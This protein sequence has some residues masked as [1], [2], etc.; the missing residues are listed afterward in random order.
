MQSNRLSN[1]GD[2]TKTRTKNQFNLIC[3]FLF[4][5]SRITRLHPLQQVIFIDFSHVRDV[6]NDMQNGCA[7]NIFHRNKKL[8]YFTSIQAAKQIDTIEIYSRLQ[9]SRSGLE[10]IFV[11]GLL[12]IFAVAIPL[13]TYD[14]LITHLIDS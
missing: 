5:L 4:I 1:T 7:G 11:C 13:R 10:Q 9:N 8:S 3:F 6:E 14:H 2:R 12:R